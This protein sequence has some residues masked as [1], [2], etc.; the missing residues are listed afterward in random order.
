MTWNK[1]MTLQSDLSFYS[2]YQPFQSELRR[3]L[4]IQK[5]LT[6]ILWV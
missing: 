1:Y 4:I 2:V 3:H 5:T 6:G